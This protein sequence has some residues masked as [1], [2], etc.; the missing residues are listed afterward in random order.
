M[1]MRKL[2]AGVIAAATMLGGLALGASTAN[3]ADGDVTITVNNAQAGHTYTPYRFATFGTPQQVDGKTYVEVKVVNEAWNTALETALTTSTAAQGQPSNALVTKGTD[4]KYTAGAQDVSSYSSNWAAYVATLTPAQLRQF[5]ALLTAPTSTQASGAAL[6]PSEEQQG[7]SQNITTAGEGWYLVTDSYKSGD[8]AVSGLNAIVATSI[9][10]VTGDF[11]TGDEQT[12]QGNITA[13]GAFN[14]KN[15]NIPTVDKTV[16][17]AANPNVDFNGQT[18]KIG[19]KLSFAVKGYIPSTASGYDS[20]PYYIKDVA[21]KGLT[22]NNGVKVYAS[23]DANLDTAADTLL[24]ANAYTLVG[25]TVQ[26]DTTTLTEVSFTDAKSYA[27][28]YIFVTYTATVNADVLENANK[29]T[30][31]AQVSRDNQNWS[32]PKKTENDTLSFE[33]TKTNKDGS[34]K[35]EG[36]TFSI[37]DGQTAL[38]FVALATKGEYRLVTSDDTN[39]VNVVTS[40]ASGKIVVKGLA[41]G[42][43]T[44]TE[45]TAPAGYSSTFKPTFTV[46]IAKGQAQV[47]TETGS[48]KYGLVD[49]VKNEV[50]NVKNVS[51]LPL[52]GAAGTA[53]F[54]VIGLL[55]AG[56]AATVALKSRETKR[57]LRA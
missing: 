43:Y 14:A 57:A 5:A 16:A 42:T 35:L 13:L 33:F 19:Q 55:L 25:P 45:E 20:Y 1:R 52:T 23:D 7:T 36:A 8:T 21:S 51:E 3:A 6:T 18:V 53:L 30:N 9:N 11:V 50:H 12:G 32:D 24:P 29:V 27:G 15:E 17:D 56:A 34:E 41:A 10:G 46:T 48:V 49:S 38:R 26:N 2:F 44:V 22:V 40:P 4:G 39:T 28:K 37:K 47:L 31:E 54:T